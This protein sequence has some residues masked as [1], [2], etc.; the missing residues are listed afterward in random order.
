MEK[1]GLVAGD[2]AFGDYFTGLLR[3]L[4]IDDAGGSIEVCLSEGY[5]GGAILEEYARAHGVES[6]TPLALAKALACFK[7][8]VGGEGR[9]VALG[10]DFIELSQTKCEFGEPRGNDYSGNLCGVCRAVTGSIARASG[11][12]D[13]EGLPRFESTMARGAR[14]CDFTIALSGP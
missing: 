1:C 10:P 14:S 2:S 9:I 13:A 6:W 12:V 5:Q 8:R 7:V 4:S 3:Y 11:I